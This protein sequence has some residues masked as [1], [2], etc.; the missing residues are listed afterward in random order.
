MIQKQISL[1]GYLPSSLGAYITPN[2]QSV[3]IN[4]HNYNI[5]VRSQDAYDL[6]FSMN[7]SWGFQSSITS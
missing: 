3:I 7:K 2:P 5:N 6:K 4:G 1:N